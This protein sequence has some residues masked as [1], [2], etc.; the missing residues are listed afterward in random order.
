MKFQYPNI[1]SSIL[2]MFCMFILMEVMPIEKLSAQIWEPEGINLPGG[3]N[4]WSNPPYGNL[5]LASATQ[6]S[7]GRVTKITS[8]TVRWQTWFKVAASGGDIVG[9]SYPFLF[10]SGSASNPWGNTWKDVTVAMNTLQTYTYQGSSDNQIT[11]VNGKWYTMNWKDSG[12]TGTQAIFMETSALPV[13]ISAVTVPAL[14]VAGSPINI[15]MTTSSIPCPE[16]IFYLRYSTDAWVTSQ[17]LQVSMAGSTGTVIL[18]A[19]TNGTSVSC[20]AFSSALAGV[21]SDY[22]MKSIKINNNGGLNYSI[23]VGS[24]QMSVSTAA[25]SAITGNSAVSGGTI[26]GSGGES[27][28]ARGVCWSTE[29]NPD[30]TDSFTTDGAGEG[31]FTSALAGLSPASA[32][33]V[34]AYATTTS[35]TIYGSDIQFVTHSAISFMVDMAT[36][37]G[38]QPGIDAVYLSGGFPGTSWITPGDNPSM[39]MVA[40]QPGSLNYSL[41]LYLPA[42]SYEY[43]HFLN[44]GWNGGEWSGGSNRQVTVNGNST[45]QN[46]W[47]GE[48][49]WANLQ[50]P[51]NGSITQGAPLMVYSRVTIP[52]GKT[53]V[54]GGAYGISAWI[55]Y[56]T[57]NTHPDTWTNWVPASYSGVAGAND[58]YVTDLGSVL[59]GAGIFY[60]A[61]RFQAGTGSFFYG[62]YNS[63]FWD[64]SQNVSGVLTVNPVSTEK[65]LNLKL[66]IEGLYS[67]SSLMNK[68]KNQTADQFSGTIA[69]KVNIEFH[70]PLDYPTVVFSANDVSL[71]TNGT[72][73]L[74]SIPSGFSGSYYVTVRHRNS[75]A[76]TTASP[77]AFTS[78]VTS[79]DFTTSA[80]KAF[81]S[82]LKEIG[83]AFCFFSGDVNQDGIINP[84]DKTLAENE[85]SGFQEGYLPADINGDGLMDL[86]DL[87]MIDNNSHHLVTAQ[88]P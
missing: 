65:T 58:E 88:T 56:N 84:A 67:G 40:D 10:T 83:G 60:Y 63:G 13:D 78:G 66:F 37:A 53:G 27:I 87:I 6:V 46:T 62:G 64:G 25:V 35:G 26:V 19:Q 36:A 47:G 74:T 44:S 34:R 23:P 45:L 32:Y 7:G 39:M 69:D 42:G 76:V 8:G 79:Y 55:G 11:V 77:V 70:D 22:D 31:T 48:I 57:S 16:E 41:T 81:G 85:V 20:Y 73:A 18:P 43:K 24:Q 14:A 3:W 49:S 12:Y 5:A 80:D 72:I 30:L 52:N 50:W 1:L 17:C 15:G 28:L 54:A 29:S 33:H 9:G 59:P 82:N 2:K 68:A 38:F 21:N 4:S 86:S 51:A 75:I 71:N 61:S